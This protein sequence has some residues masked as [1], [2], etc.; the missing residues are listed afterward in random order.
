MKST[1]PIVTMRKLTVNQSQMDIHLRQ[2]LSTQM[3]KIGVIMYTKARKNTSINTRKRRKNPPTKT[4][5][6]EAKIISL[7]RKSAIRTENVLKRN[8]HPVIG[9]VKREVDRNQG[10]TLR[11]EKGM[12]MLTR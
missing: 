3:L 9:R 7:M 2:V 4:R 8:G 12:M 5:K 11:G 1:L 10:K 6:N